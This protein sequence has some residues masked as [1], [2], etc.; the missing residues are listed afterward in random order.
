MN[1]ITFR[2]NISSDRFRAYYEG[3]AQNV[4]VRLADGRNLQFPANILRPFLTH[5]GVQGEFA[6]RFDNKNKLADI[7]RVAG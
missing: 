1:E 7:R 2:L 6:I 4:V 5:T 3:I